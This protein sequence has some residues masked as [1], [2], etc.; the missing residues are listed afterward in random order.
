MLQ[1]LGVLIMV[2]RKC[3][4]KLKF[5]PSQIFWP[6]PHSPLFCCIQGGFLTACEGWAPPLLLAPR[7]LADASHQA[8][9]GWGSM[10]AVCPR[11]GR[12]CGLEMSTSHVG[13]DGSVNLPSNHAR[14]DNAYGTHYRSGEDPF[15]PLDTYRCTS[16]HAQQTIPSSTLSNPDKTHSWS[17]SPEAGLAAT[18]K[19]APVV[20]LVRPFLDQNV[21]ATAR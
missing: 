20:I 8:R 16:V 10:H 17:T 13:G 14:K 11:M 3:C 2:K 9:V 5:I 4:V 12:G 1:L 19:L 15:E 6:A 7:S 21:G 18:D